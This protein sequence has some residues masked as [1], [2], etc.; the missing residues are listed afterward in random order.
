MATF[1]LR[2]LTKA[3]MWTVFKHLDTENKGRI[4]YKSLLKAFKRTSRN[5][6]TFEVQELMSEL[7]MDIDDEITFDKFVHAIT[8]QNSLNNS[9]TFSPTP[10]NRRMNES[11]SYIGGDMPSSVGESNN[12]CR[13]C[14]F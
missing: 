13:A 12:N 2:N 4:T 8:C 3:E 10:K 5:E 14:K 11:D 6:C 9:I 1:D 7:N